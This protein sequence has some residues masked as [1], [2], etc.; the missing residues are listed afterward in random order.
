MPKLA[1]AVHGGAGPDSEFIQKN[2]DGYKIG[3]E[4]AINAGYKVLQD[5]GSAMDA[6]EAAVN[7]MENS[8]LFNAGRGSALNELAEVEMDASIMNGKELKPGAVSIVKNVKNP[9]T[10]ARAIME[11]SAHIYLG[12]NGALEFA[13]KVGLQLMPEAY[14]ITDHAFEEYSKALEESTNTIEE[15]GQ[16]QAKRKTHGT[17]GAV[18]LDKDGVFSPACSQA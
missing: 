8:A 1:I 12:D 3:L 9:V 4:E 2:K 10:L 16:Y 14:F 11:K 13:R 7:V 18:A 6:V 5:G 15:A 17:V